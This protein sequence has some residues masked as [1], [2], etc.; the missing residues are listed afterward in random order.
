[1]WTDSAA[2]RRL[3]ES[4]G[5]F[6]HGIM[7]NTRFRIEFRHHIVDSVRKWHVTI[8]DKRIMDKIDIIDSACSR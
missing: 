1:M 7:A 3:D 2:R 6:K 4:E 5:E 8:R